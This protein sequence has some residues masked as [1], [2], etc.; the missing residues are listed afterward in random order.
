MIERGQKVGYG[1]LNMG[2]DMRF[3]RHEYSIA[4]ME[5]NQTE[6]YERIE[7]MRTSEQNTQNQQRCKYCN[8]I[9]G[10]DSQSRKH[11]CDCRK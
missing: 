10:C 11:K 8:R 7:A 5:S 1:L 6:F 4:E 3:A 9:V 2:N